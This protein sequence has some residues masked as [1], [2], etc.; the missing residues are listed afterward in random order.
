MLGEFDFLAET[1]ASNESL[2]VWHRMAQDSHQISQNSLN[3]IKSWSGMKHTHTNT[4]THK[5][6]HTQTHTHKHIHTQ[7]HTHTNTYTHTHI[8]TQTHIHTNT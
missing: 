7:T 5:H 6:I 4:H 1:D 2:N 3:W 8:H